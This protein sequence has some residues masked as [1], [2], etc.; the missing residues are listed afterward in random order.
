MIS[1]LIWTATK[2]LDLP[3]ESSKVHPMCYKNIKHVDS[4]TTLVFAAV[5]IFSLHL[6][7]AN[8]NAWSSY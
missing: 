2:F 4:C 6:L 8:D 1:T 7:L 5:Q 3:Q